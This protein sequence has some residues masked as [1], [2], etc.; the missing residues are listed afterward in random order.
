MTFSNGI[1]ASML[2]AEYQ[3]ANVQNVVAFL[4]SSK[5]KSQQESTNNINDDRGRPMNFAPSELDPVD[6]LRNEV[7]HLL[8]RRAVD[9]DDWVSETLCDIAAGNRTDWD[10]Q[11]WTALLTGLKRTELCITDWLDLNV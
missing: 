7:G 1:Y 11:D 5:K 8:V 3:Q 2:A 6:R 10:T 9:R 4:I